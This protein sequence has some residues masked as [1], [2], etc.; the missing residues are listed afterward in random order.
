MF[1][2][3]Q[4]RLFAGGGGGG[5]VCVREREFSKINYTGPLK[6]DYNSN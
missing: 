1:N 2:F 6:R 5:G 4:N 3:K